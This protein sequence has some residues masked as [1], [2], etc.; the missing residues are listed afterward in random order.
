H[1]G[2]AEAVAGHVDDVVDAAGDPVEAVFVAAAAVA[3]E[4]PA[5]VSREVRLHE[6]LVVAIDGAHL[7][8]PG[9]DDAEIAGGRAFERLAFGIHD[10]RLDA[11]EWAC[12]RTRFQFS[13]AGQRRDEDAAGLGLP[14]GIDDR[15]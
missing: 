5:L 13:R 8:R 1:F 3:G 11:E 6:A 10:L 4:I 14:P 2:G 9:V 15:A 7:P 12:R